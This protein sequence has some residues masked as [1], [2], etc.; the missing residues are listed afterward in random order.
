[1][2]A[3]DSL[4]V[5]ALVKMNNK[6]AMWVKG[7]SNTT[8]GCKVLMLDESSV[9][10]DVEWKTGVTW[11]E[12]CARI[13]WSCKRHEGWVEQIPWVWDRQSGMCVNN[14]RGIS[15]NE[16]NWVAVKV[17]TEVIENLLVRNPMK[18]LVSQKVKA[19]SSVQCCICLCGGTKFLWSS[20]EWKALLKRPGI[21]LNIFC[22]PVLFS[23][24]NRQVL[25]H[26]MSR[27]W[28]WWSLI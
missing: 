26:S 10:K 12:K 19:L 4:V 16:Q 24:L 15:G 1:M 6:G 20:W 2:Y 14:E 5:N 28:Q 9:I 23:N 22:L 11:N 7:Y 8:Y 13:V 21:T 18:H 27:K 3:D 17:S 25:H